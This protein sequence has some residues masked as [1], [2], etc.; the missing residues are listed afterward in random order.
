ML[1]LSLY[2]R[3]TGLPEQLVT[4]LGFPFRCLPNHSRH[5]FLRNAHRDQHSHS[6][7]VG[8]GRSR[9]WLPRKELRNEPRVELPRAKIR[10]P[11]DATEK[12]DVGLN[13]RDRKLVKRT[14]HSVDGVLPG[15]GP[16]RELGK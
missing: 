7:E 15:I 9:R 1:S 6:F 8:T 3:Q 13:P 2:R 4:A 5:P 16:D 10:I 14:E 11:Q 12:R